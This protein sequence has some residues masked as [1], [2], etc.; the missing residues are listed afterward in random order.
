M[1]KRLTTTMVVTAA[2]ALTACPQKAADG[3][4]P[5][6]AT[7]KAKPGPAS[8]PAVPGAASLPGQPAPPGPP[9]ADGEQVDR[10]F[11]PPRP[12]NDA[13][14]ARDPEVFPKRLGIKRVFLQADKINHLRDPQFIPGTTDLLAMAKVGGLQGLWVLPSDGSTAARMVFAR[15]LYTP[16]EKADVVNRGN[17]Y[18]GTPAL[19]PDGKHAIFGG[20]QFSPN[21]KYGNVLGLAPLKG[22]GTIAGITVEGVTFA[23]T[24]D[25]HPDGKTIVFA[26]CTEIRKA[27]LKGRKTQTVTSEV[28]VDLKRLDTRSKAVCTVNRPRFSPDGSQIVF[29]V[30]GQ[31]LHEDLK[32]Q[33]KVPLPVN[34]GDYLIEPWVANVDGTGVRRLVQDSTYERDLHGRLQSGGSKDPSWFPDGK[35]VVFSHGRQMAV[36]TVDGSKGK[37]ISVP[38][39]AT[40]R[41][42]K[43]I[44]GDPVVSS[45]G[46][47]AAFASDVLG[48]ESNPRPAPPGISVLDL[49][50]VDL[51]AL[52]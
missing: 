52:D 48:T 37:L 3:D 26:S 11:L 38:V 9:G 4:P 5:K 12:A 46:K 14:Y 16:G 35:K 49:T 47:L 28:I 32:E 42:V 43:F 40:N 50:K 6:A 20:T 8:A 29:E 10:A 7:E 21:A 13:Q 19:F 1:M 36:V 2:L 15:P 31:F 18:I 34:D 39:V 45:D 27:T 24:P 41:A 22:A 33:Y 17:W 23:R 51:S 30:N 44:E 25:V